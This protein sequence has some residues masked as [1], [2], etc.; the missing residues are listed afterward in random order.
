MKKISFLALAAM[1][2]C[3]VSASA[4]LTASV[5]KQHA[6]MR[7]NTMD[8]EP[9][10]KNT[11]VMRRQGPKFNYADMEESSNSRTSI[12]KSTEV[13]AFPNPFINEL[14]LSVSDASFT[15][16]KYEAEVYTLQGKKVYSQQLHN[17]QCGLSLSSLSAGMYILQVQK[18]GTLVLQEKV[19]K[20]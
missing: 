14:S 11:P 20:E 1:S 15:N 17:A 19:V 6:A 10:K 4:Q 9:P 7:I 16:S 8:K 13:H 2:L 5:K 3:A 12:V 18:N